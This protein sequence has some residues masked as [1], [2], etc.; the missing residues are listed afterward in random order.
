MSELSQPLMAASVE[1]MTR[2]AE[3]FHEALDE[4]T[5]A[6]LE[7]RGLLEAGIH[8]QLGR[9]P[10][11]TSP[12]WRQY[13]GRLAIPFLNGNGD[14]VLIRFRDLSG[15]STAKY[16][17]MTDSNNVPYNLPALISGQR[18]INVCEGEL[19]ALT[20]RAMGFAA[21][22]I[23]GAN[24]WKPHYRKLL[25]PFER[26][27]VWGDNDDAG[28]SFNSTVKASAR[29]AQPAYLEQDINDSYI[30]DGGME[31][32]SAFAEAGGLE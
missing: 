6:Y 14:C 32:L 27:L 1:A 21:I 2:A 23:T 13:A 28:R 24:G 11:D 12:A 18:T 9:V 3:Q 10:A 30:S 15:N 8:A 19:D 5:T 22:G 17:Q 4:S 25:D 26:V 31:I 16:L 29:Q 20:L 7:G